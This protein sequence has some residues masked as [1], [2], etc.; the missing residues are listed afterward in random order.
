[1]RG[2]MRPPAT[3]PVRCRGGTWR[4]VVSWLLLTGGASGTSVSADIVYLKSGGAV[5]GVVVE[6]T[7][8]AVTVRT[9]VGMVRL[10]ADRVDRIEETE[11]PL[12]EYDRR[13]SEAATAD[14][15]VE[16]AEWCT[17]QR[18]TGQARQHYEQA[19]TLDPD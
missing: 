11:S 3:T 12:A 19:L 5:R 10:A 7:P 15:H 2:S 16:L 1:M 4:P 13:A 17:E 6:R 14:A 8:E 18:L 9:Q